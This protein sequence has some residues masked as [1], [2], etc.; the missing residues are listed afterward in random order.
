MHIRPNKCMHN[1]IHG[2]HSLTGMDLITGM[3][4]KK[5]NITCTDLYIV[6]WIINVYALM[7]NKKY[8]SQKAIIFLVC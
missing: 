4:R 1:S 3:G 7:N 5:L 2:V 8:L 6:S